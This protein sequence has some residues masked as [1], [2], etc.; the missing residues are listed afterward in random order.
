MS[1]PTLLARPDPSYRYKIVP[2]SLGIHEWSRLTLLALGL[3]LANLT[4][5]LD[6]LTC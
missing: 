1:L 2:P 5:A 4:L 3:I 6:L